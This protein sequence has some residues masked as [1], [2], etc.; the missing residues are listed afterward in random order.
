MSFNCAQS[1]KVPKNSAGGA[2]EVSITR[3]DLFFKQK[4]NATGNRSGIS[5][6][7]VNIYVVPVTLGIPAMLEIDSAP[8]ARLSWSEVQ[9]SPTATIAS[10]FSFPA[11]VQIHTDKEYAI[12]VRFD[13]DEDFVLWKNKIGDRLVG[14]SQVS[15][16]PDGNFVGSYFDYTAGAQQAAG[17]QA[18]T[19]YVTTSTSNTQS[20]YPQAN[21]D[22][23]RPLADTDLKFLVNIARYAFSGNVNMS[24]QNV[25]SMV[26]TAL[27]GTVSVNN[28]TGE[29]TYTMPSTRVE[30]VSFDRTRSQIR[31]VL[32][33]EKA[34]QNT[35][36]YPGGKVNA[37]TLSV[38]SNTD[39]ITSNSSGIN[40]STYFA[41]GL[42]NPSYIVVVSED[43]DGAGQDLAAVRQISAI[44]SN[45]SIRV[46]EKLPFTNTAA[47]F[48]FSPVAV[49][50]QTLTARFFG[51]E[52]DVMLLVQSAANSSMR[53]V[54]DSILELSVNAAGNGYHNTDYVQVTGFQNVSGV[55]MGNYPANAQVVTDGN[56]A[57]TA[58]YMSNL[59][60]GFINTAAITCAVKNSTGGSSNGTGA[61]FVSNV[62][63]IIK[64]ELLG[65]D[66]R[67][68]H[69]S[70]CRPINI[71]VGEIFPAPAINNPQGT[72]FRA[73]HTL[74]YYM[75]PD[76]NTLDGFAYY[77]DT[78]SGKDTYEV[79][80]G[81]V[82]YPWQF[83]KRRVLPSWSNELVIPYANGSQSNGYGG[84]V[85]S[86][87]VSQTGLLSNAS[88]LT[89]KTFSNNDF[90]AAAAAPNFST[91]TF[92]RYIV[93]DDYTGE[94]TNY[95]NSWAKGVE[96]K[97]NLAVNATSE[98]IRIFSTVYRPP[99][100]DIQ[101]YARLKAEDDFEAF[102]DKDWTRLEIIDGENLRSSL[103]NVDDFVEITWGLQ[104]YPNTS[105]EITGSVT[106]ELSN[107]VLVGSGTNF[108]NLAAGD[109]VLVIN[110]LF[111]NNHMV[112]VV[113]AV[114]N[115]TQMSLVDAVSNNGLVGTG[116][117][118]YKCGY[119]HQAFNNSLN[120]NVAR[121][122]DSS[123]VPHDTF[124]TCQLK[125]VM[126][127]SNNV[128]V[129]RLDDV[130]VVCI[131]A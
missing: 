86:G 108:T 14:S 127:S 2:A 35:V 42:S 58:V 74:A 69:I 45:T 119:P 105:L 33:G 131:S 25:S 6:P 109:L 66:G 48:F 54:G 12:V 10:K 36:F 111:P 117:K 27:T 16:A 91:V 107:T 102:D 67:G 23:W 15:T 30:Y 125:V 17:I 41:N 22:T 87:N 11:P 63:S 47:K 62:G 57:I 39:L 28:S 34:Y 32:P 38:V 92:S 123:M 19:N 84:D 129:P 93:N 79:Q 85:P 8:S 99:N 120:E 52:T 83:T 76:A 106:T 97:L 29:V 65:L 77:C 21:P 71:E 51:V 37:Y 43:H 61:T 124:K 122:Y 94:H 128:I 24:T 9:I 88:V 68:G 130:R 20:L 31:N 26:N 80:T 50:D 115:T 112:S 118:V 13:G 7:G 4:P 104:S 110:P 64:T 72:V 113:N 90:V 78:N 56:G 81:A 5:N 70:N 60:S 95:G 96:V 75:V 53:F 18:N 46:T 40:F 126:T 100:T 73:F 3:I 1:F 49:V 82:E 114:T 101:M 89:I 116:F 59:G 44:V 55:I 121:Y 103:T 98:D